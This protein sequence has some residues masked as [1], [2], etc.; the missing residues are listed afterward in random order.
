MNDET[1]TLPHRLTETRTLAGLSQAGL[2]KK[3]GLSASLISH[4]EKGTRTPSGTQLFDLARNMGVALDYLLNAEI[5]PN[6]KCRA[7]VKSAQ[8][9]DV[10]QALKDASAQVHFVATAYR[11]A[12]KLPKPF[13][14]RADFGSMDTLPSLAAHLR[15]TLKLNRRVTLDEFKQA[16]SD[17]NIFVFEWAMPHD[18]SGLSLRGAFSVIFI[19]HAHPPTR[20]LFTLAHEFAHIIFHL[21]RE[22]GGGEQGQMQTQVSITS[23]RD[24]I[25]KE[26]NAFAGELLMPRADLEALVKKYDIQL[27]DPSML[28]A[29]ARHFNVSRD[30]IFYRLAQMEFFTWADKRDYFHS[31]PTLPPPPPSRIKDADALDEQVDGRFREAALSL[32]REGKITTS[33]LAEWFFVPRHVLEEE[34]L[35]KLREP[36]E[37]AISDEPVAHGEG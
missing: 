13:A 11:L 3:L 24:P 28:E 20:R 8:Q 9:D 21:G 16:L 29:V 34:Y 4:W 27:R 22:A 17:W 1:H 30:A 32:F 36:G 12:G 19:N 18:L 26:A 5:R 15:E 14:L 10:D 25:E 33:K 7:K 35:V 23:T 2:A 31:Q 37:Q 6:F